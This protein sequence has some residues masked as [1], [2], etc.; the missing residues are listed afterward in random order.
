[1][2]VEKALEP[3]VEPII[4]GCSQHDGEGRTA[5]SPE[6][7][8]D[9]TVIDQAMGSRAFLVHAVH[10]LAEAYRRALLAAGAPEERLASAEMASVKR[11]IA[12]RCIYGI[13]LN[14]M[15]VELAK[16]SLWLETMALSEP[17]SFLDAH[18]RCGDSLIGAPEELG[19][20]ARASTGFRNTRFPP[21]AGM[22]RPRGRTP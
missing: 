4:Q 21:F 8:L 3:L 13:D 7:I 12:Q 14:P 11:L 6:E 15:A 9:L 1:M 17:L 10:L 19:D 22:L 20:G 16:V 2:I 5:R 18:L